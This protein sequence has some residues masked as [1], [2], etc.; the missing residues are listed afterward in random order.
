M[1]FCYPLWCVVIVDGI[2]YVGGDV[3]TVGYVIVG[4]IVGVV[5]VVIVA[6][7]V[8]GGCYIND[9]GGRDGVTVV[10]VVLLLILLL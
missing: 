7:T 6:V 9:C 1:Y 5:V 3:V 8:C 4:G 2:G 10:V